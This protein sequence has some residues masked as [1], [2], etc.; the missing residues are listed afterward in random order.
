[1]IRDLTLYVGPMFSGKTQALINN[2]EK[3]RDGFKC[4]IVIL[5]WDNDI[6]ENEN[7]YDDTMCSHSKYMKQIKCIRVQRDLMNLE[8]LEII[9]DFDVIGIDDG[10]FF[11]DLSTFCIFLVENLNKKVLVSSLD[12]DSNRKPF[13]EVAKLMCS[14]CDNIYKFSSICSK[15]NKNKG[16]FSHKT[17]NGGDRIDVGGHNKY[18]AVCRDCYVHVNCPNKWILGIMGNIGSGKSTLSI[19]LKNYFYSKNPK[20]YYTKLKNFYGKTQVLMEAPDPKYLKK[21]YDNTKKNW[22]WFQCYMVNKRYDSIKNLKNNKGLLIV[23]RWLTEDK[24]FPENLLKTG[25][26]DATRYKI[27]TSQFKKLLNATP[28]P[29]MLLF[30][31]VPAEQCYKNLRKR[32]NKSEEGVTLDYIKSLEIQYKKLKLSLIKKHSGFI[33]YHDDGDLIVLSKKIFIIKGFYKK[34][35]DYYLNLIFNSINK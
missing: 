10:H 25:L 1:M 11:N 12:C 8:T 9:N 6:R 4:K 33:E 16:L 3:L 5:K 21:F 30:L 20:N 35:I 19:K 13:K 31:D 22:F 28:E 14:G 15:C 29:D 18:I 27:Y 32:N 23:D 24:I 26:A 34:P 7:K 17:I 2:I